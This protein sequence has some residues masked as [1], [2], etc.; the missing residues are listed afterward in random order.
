MLVAAAHLGLDFFLMPKG[1]PELST[2]TQLEM[3]AAWG[4]RTQGCGHLFGKTRSQGLKW[5]QEHMWPHCRRTQAPGWPHGVTL[6]MEGLGGG[7]GARERDSE[8]GEGWK[9]RR[10]VS[11]EPRVNTSLL[12]GVT[13]SAR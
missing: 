11:P 4:V 7:R 8:Q 13:E 9:N 12:S 5:P 3:H 6:F 2:Q 1:N 10:T